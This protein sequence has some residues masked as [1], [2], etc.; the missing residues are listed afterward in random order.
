LDEITIGWRAIYGG[1]HMKLG[2]EPDIAC[3]AKSVSNGY[4][5]GAILGREDVMQAA[6]SSFI[7]STYWTEAIGFTAALATLRKMK[8]VDLP[9]HVTRIGRRCQEGVDECIRKHGL[10]AHVGGLPVLQHLSF[11]YGD[12]S[13]AVSTLLT[14]LMLERGFLATGQF[15]PTY[16]HTEAL[17]D[18]YL[19]A[20]DESFSVIK[21]AVDND[22]ILTNLKGPIAHSGFQRLT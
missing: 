21:D 9:G 22:K 17:V 11:D 2:V 15:Y 18:Q 10:K 16:A 5:M 4:P 13:R 14:Q 19:T 20:L 12:S 8:A 6:Q 3:F 1:M 7:S